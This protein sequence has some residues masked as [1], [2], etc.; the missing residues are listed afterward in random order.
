MKRPAARAAAK[1]EKPAKRPV[2]KRPAARDIKKSKRPAKPA[3]KS[4]VNGDTAPLRVQ[5]LYISGEPM[6]SVIARSFWKA[7]DVKTVVENHT[8]KAVL[9]LTLATG[10]VLHTN[11]TLAEIGLTDGD[12]VQAV[13]GKPERR[14]YRF[15]S[16]E[17]NQSY[18]LDSD[19]FDERGI[20]GLDFSESPDSQLGSADECIHRCGR[21]G[22]D[23][24]GGECRSCYDEH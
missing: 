2:A 8:K 13:L 16:S 24:Y 9:Q 1:S 15:D 14:H 6:V 11:E 20:P 22:S 19:E 10:R 4:P 21:R 17:S 7:S 23:Y 3:A 5:V 12:Q 18:F